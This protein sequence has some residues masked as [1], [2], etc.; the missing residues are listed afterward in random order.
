MLDDL[1][2]PEVPG[3]LRSISPALPRQASRLINALLDVHSDLPLP[4]R[5][6]RLRDVSTRWENE[7]WS[8]DLRAV[9]LVLADLL[10][11]GWGVLPVGRSI[12]LRPPGSRLEGE[13]R[14]S[15][16][17]RLRHGLR[18]HRARQLAEPGVV[19]FLRR[20]HRPVLR[21]GRRTSIRDV[22][23]DGRA[24]APMLKRCQLLSSEAATEQLGKIIQP[25]LQVCEGDSRCDHTGL[26][27]VDIWR[28]FRHTWSNEYRP[29]PG[30]SMQ[31]LIRNAARPNHPIIGIAMLASPVVRL[32][33]RDVWMGWIPDAFMAR[34][35]DYGD[36]NATEA[37]RALQARVD[38]S[39]GEIR[40]DDLDLNETDIAEPSLKTV[41][42]LEA[43]A[44]GAAKGRQRDLREDY[45]EMKEAEGGAIRSQRDPTKS[46]T[47]VGLDWR[48]LSEDLLYVHKRADTLA[49]LLA[50]KRVFKSLDWSLPA[51]GLRQA[52]EAHQDGRR[53]IATALAEVRKAGLSSRVADLSVCGAVAPYN[54]LIAGKLVA[55]LMASAEARELYRARYVEKVSIISSQMAGRPISRPAELKVLTTTSLYGF[56]SVQYNALR[57]RCAEHPEIPFDIDWQELRRTMGWGTYHLSS[58]TTQVL[59]LVSERMHG[60]RRVNNRF[61]E[62]ASPRLR[63]TRDGLAALG[64]DPAQILH[65]ATPR[66]FYGCELHRGA[67]DELIGLSSPCAQPAISASSITAAWVRRWLVGRIRKQDVIR[68]MELLGPESIKSDLCVSDD[69]GQLLL[70]V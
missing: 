56:A 69:T 70:A 42:R 62:G 58:D 55:L 37:L 54:S 48:A 51:T 25:I 6:Q 3:D 16:R 31:I 24:L 28:Y 50:A 20:M 57:L 8:L 10:E 11:Q 17:E 63:Q 40:T 44:A 19:A 2:E 34:I 14:D 30:R 1:G 41:M 23:D 32:R 21:L 66:I 27:L 18:A 64:I 43:R 9:A 29:I 5:I 61:G 67:L 45:E 52:L 12:E 65:H 15:A 38:A 22:I 49:K 33:S 59:R 60:S 7:G 47:T 35:G 13:T 46:G 4:Q 53:A 36:W 39:L 68:G 26:R